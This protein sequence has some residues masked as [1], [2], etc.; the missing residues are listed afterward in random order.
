M[1]RALPLGR[2]KSSLLLITLSYFSFIYGSHTESFYT[3]LLPNKL[4]IRRL[5][6]GKNNT[7]FWIISFRVASRQFHRQHLH[8]R[9]RH[10][11]SFMWS[12]HIK[13][14]LCQTLFK[15]LCTDWT[16]DQ[17]GIRK[18][19]F[20][21]LKVMLQIKIINSVSFEVNVC[22]HMISQGQN[23]KN[24]VLCVWP[25]HKGKVEFQVTEEENDMAN[26]TEKPRISSFWTRQPSGS[27]CY[28]SSVNQLF[29]F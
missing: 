5:T 6:Q 29:L 22:P 26:F 24:R 28:V 7:E 4:S 27:I 2:Q 20:K 11:Y 25:K 12:A 8:C 23:Y 19:E 16:K 14:N 21:E 3:C 15:A 9:A 13:H 17:K 10:T 18:V 1:L